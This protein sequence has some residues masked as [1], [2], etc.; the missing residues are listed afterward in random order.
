MGTEGLPFVIYSVS[1]D[2]NLK[3]KFLSGNI[4][5]LTGYSE[6]DFVK[7]P[8]LWSSILHDYDSERVLKMLKVQKENNIPIDLKYRIITKQ[9]KI[10]WV[11]DRS[12]PVFDQ[13]GNIIKICGFIEDYTDEK[14]CQ[15]KLRDFAESQEVLLREVNHRVKN[16]LM[17]V[18]SMLLKE[19]KKAKSSGITSYLPSLKNLI[20]RIYGLSTIHSI[21]SSNKGEFID[22]TLLFEKAINEILKN[23]F[24]SNN[25]GIFVSNSNLKVNSSQAHYLTLIINELLTNSVKH[26]LKEKDGKI[27][28]NISDRDDDVSITFKD[29]GEGFPANIIAGEIDLNNGG[30]SLIKDIIEK[31]L[32]GSINI[33]NNNGAVVNFIF[34]PDQGSNNKNLYSLNLS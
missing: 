13:I 32:S 26:A 2:E 9:K 14:T 6:N 21:L 7:N 22:L 34:K 18:L 8:N 24:P 17:A 30:F 15:G 5:D 28:V 23:R 29:N 27:T 4:F 11:R 19:E 31:N 12:S 3:I 10:K 1:S 25:I 20:T 33:S 16:N